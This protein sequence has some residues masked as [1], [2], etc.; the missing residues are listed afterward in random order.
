M[1]DPDREEEWR[2]KKKIN[3]ANT[4]A[5]RERDG[6]KDAHNE[7]RNRKRREQARQDRI[8]AVDEGVPV[9]VIIDRRVSLLFLYIMKYFVLMNRKRREAPVST[10]A[11]SNKPLRPRRS[12]S[13]RPCWTRLGARVARVASRPSRSSRTR[14]SLL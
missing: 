10:S 4:R 13:S 1:E 9:Q 2:E 6:T 8:D 14:H 12:P 7:E 5:R 3:N 11:S